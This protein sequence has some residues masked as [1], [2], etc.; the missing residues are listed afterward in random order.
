MKMKTVNVCAAVAALIMG[1][2]SV[3]AQS[4]RIL[5]EPYQAALPIAP[6]PVSAAPF[7]PAPIIRTVELPSNPA[8]PTSTGFNVV[9]SD[10][11]IREV[12]SRWAGSAGWTHGPDHWAIDR[13][14][15][16]AGEADASL[17]GSDFKEAAR[18]L[19]ASSEFTDRPVQPCFYSNK[20]L[21]VVSKA[22]LC[23]KSSQTV[24]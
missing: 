22:E 3:M 5:D 17:F 20:I 13:D 21:R 2:S 10:K 8:V 9:G 15:P 6:A 16:I 1:A 11:T 24:Q 4:V 19:L 18:R 14:L 12:L 7:A 23:D